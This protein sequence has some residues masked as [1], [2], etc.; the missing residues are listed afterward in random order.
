MEL[1]TECQLPKCQLPNC[2]YSKCQLYSKCHPITIIYYFK[3]TLQSCEVLDYLNIVHQGAPSTFQPPLQFCQSPIFLNGCLPPWW[4]TFW[5]LTFW[6]EPSLWTLLHGGTFCTTKAVWIEQGACYWSF[7]V[8]QG[9]CTLLSTFPEA[10]TTEP[11]VPLTC[12]KLKYQDSLG[13][14]CDWKE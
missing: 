4:W 7:E 2:L 1:V 8:L 12:H 3:Y 6:T 10:F 11:S 14:C 5:E 13:W 9:H